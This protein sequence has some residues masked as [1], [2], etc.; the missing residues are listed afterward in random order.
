MSGPCAE[1]AVATNAPSKHKML[2]QASR[3]GE[4]LS[5]RNDTVFQITTL[6]HAELYVDVTQLDEDTKHRKVRR[7][8]HH[9]SLAQRRAACLA[10]SASVCVVRGSTSRIARAPTSAE[11][12]PACAARLPSENSAVRA[13]RRNDPASLTASSTATGA[14]CSRGA[15]A[16]LLH[17]PTKSLK[18]IHLHTCKNQ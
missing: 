7:R 8:P 1:R 16:H 15:S 4:I 10:K 14:P 18:D 3:P 13:A 11:R 9:A 5:D 2:D 6:F 17:L 12:P